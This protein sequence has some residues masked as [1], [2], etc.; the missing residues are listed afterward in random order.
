ML[1]AANP[2]HR[3]MLISLDHM[4]HA[5]DVQRQKAGRS[6]GL[7]L[8]L[9][10][11]IVIVIVTVEQI[12]TPQLSEASGVLQNVVDNAYVGVG[13]NKLGPH[14]VASETDLFKWLRQAFL[15]ALVGGPMHNYQKKH[16][17]TDPTDHIRENCAIDASLEGGCI[18]SSVPVWESEDSGIG[19]RFRRPFEHKQVLRKYNRIMGGLRIEQTRGAFWPCSENIGNFRGSIFSDDTTPW[20]PNDVFASN[21]IDAAKCEEKATGDASDATDRA[22]CAAGLDEGVRSFCLPI[23]VYT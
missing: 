12:D 3:R 14:D 17:S 2:Q 13:A 6:T 9:V 18:Q 20:N 10:N 1:I 7:K 8:F 19:G 16:Q 15:P 22:A 5:I 4:R 11:L 21:E 23:L